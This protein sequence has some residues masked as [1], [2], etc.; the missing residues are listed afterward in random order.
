[1]NEQGPAVAPAPRR[2]L[3]GGLLVRRERWGLSLPAKLVIIAFLLTFTMSFMRWGFSFLAVDAPIYSDIL[4]VE[5]W[6]PK[7]GLE[8]AIGQFRTGGYRQMLTSGGP[9]YIELGMHPK[10]TTAE[11]G[12]ERI[13]SLG[14]PKDFVTAVPSWVEK[15]DRTYWSAVA[16]KRWLQ[17]NAASTK[18][19]NVLTVGPHARRTRLMYQK[20]F[21][22]DFKVG[23]ISVADPEYNPQH[24]WRTSEGV[25]DVVGETVAYIYAR[26]LFRPSTS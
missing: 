15:K 5:G 1:M 9:A 8:Q 6:I 17:R 14:M 3:L 13:E 18:A 2:R 10:E 22:D 24:W 11:W 7:F 23:I 25:R 21:G 20:A 12:A 4:V 19:I 16:V 26:L